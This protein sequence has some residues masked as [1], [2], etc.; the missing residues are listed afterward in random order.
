MLLYRIWFNTLLQMRFISVCSNVLKV[1]GIVSYGFYII[2]GYILFL[3]FFGDISTWNGTCINV[4]FVLQ[5]KW[6]EGRNWSGGIKILT[7]GKITI[8][9]NMITGF[10]YFN[11]EEYKKNY[12]NYD[13]LK[14]LC[15]Y[16]RTKCLSLIFTILL[17]SLYK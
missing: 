12:K 4:Y 8:Y 1:K 9:S 3:F 15:F 7:I 2:I 6:L 10:T 17:V 16:W 11:Y 13:K 5:E 14:W